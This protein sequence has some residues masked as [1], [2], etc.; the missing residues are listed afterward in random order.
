MQHQD[1]TATIMVEQT[2]EQAFNA[3][4]NVRGWWSE[5]IEGS[6]NK[7]G[8]EFTYHYQDIHFSRMKI[9]ELIPNEKIVWLVMDNHFNFTTDKTEWKDTKISFE[10]SQR[11]N[12][13]Q[14]Q[15]THLGLVPQYECYNICKDAW[16]HYIHDSL[17]SLISTGMGQP[18]PK[19]GG[20]NQQLIDE[21]TSNNQ[22]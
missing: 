10:I 4:T 15:F 17:R 2:P 19:E 22:L 8:D 16:S 3:I 6:T 5:E 7:L 20:F 14:I 18:N 12:K 13:T 9:I 11:E 1:F 21:Y